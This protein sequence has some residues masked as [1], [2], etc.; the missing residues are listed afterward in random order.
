M[1]HL[2]KKQKFVLGY[3]RLGHF[4]PSLNWAGYNHNN[5]MPGSSVPSLATPLFGETLDQTNTTDTRRASPWELSRSHKSLTI[6]NETCS[7]TETGATRRATTATTTALFSHSDFPFT[8]T[9]NPT[10]Y[11]SSPSTA[12]VSDAYQSDANDS[13]NNREFSPSTLSSST[14]FFP[15][16]SSFCS[17]S[18]FPTKFSSS[19]EP[20]PKNGGE[21]IELDF[22]PKGTEPTFSQATGPPL[23]PLIIDV[24]AFK[25]E[26]LTSPPSSW[27]WTNV[28]STGE[29]VEA[30]C[31]TPITP[32]TAH[33]DAERSF[34]PASK[35]S[36]M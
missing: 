23:S 30:A 25:V 29:R 6:S 28:L 20:P 21:N 10:H 31:E 5:S 4:C 35:T 13:A 8:T 34:S 26:T 14:S 33:N 15:S 2:S 36:R 22:L 24:N 9:E 7:S 27:L 11:V 16:C 32:P 1:F 17:Y 18:S 12:S 19:Q 3:F